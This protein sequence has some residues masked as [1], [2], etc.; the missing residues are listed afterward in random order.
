MRTEMKSGAE[1]NGMVGGFHVMT[2]IR[3]LFQLRDV[4]N[5]ENCQES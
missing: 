4:A 1:C 2:C 5:S 3:T